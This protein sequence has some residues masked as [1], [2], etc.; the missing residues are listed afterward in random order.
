MVITV[1]RRR[2]LYDAYQNKSPGDI[3]VPVGKLKIIH[4]QNGLSVARLHTTLSRINIPVL[5]YD[6][7]LVGDKL[8]IA[9]AYFEKSKKQK[10]S[11]VKPKP[12]RQVAVAML[13]P[14]YGPERPAEPAKKLP[15]N[16]SK[17]SDQPEINNS[18]H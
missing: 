12:Q 15:E 11:E 5:E 3:K 4:V 1:T 2:A 17:K 8:D 6:F 10:V 16:I 9:S 18:I 7:I 13:E 14:T